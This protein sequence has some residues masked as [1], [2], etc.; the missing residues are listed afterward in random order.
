[1]SFKTS[2][3][4]HATGLGHVLITCFFWPLIT[5]RS[6]YPDR[7]TFK[8]MLGHVIMNQP[9]RIVFRARETWHLGIASMSFFTHRLGKTLLKQTSQSRQSITFIFVFFEIKTVSIY[10]SE[11]L[12]LLFYV[13]VECNEWKYTD[14]GSW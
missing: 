2:R 13:S 7:D 12:S 11:N 14:R 4:N 8:F 1:M 10:F 3:H 5:F 6:M 9:M